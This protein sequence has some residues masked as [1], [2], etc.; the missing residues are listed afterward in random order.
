MVEVSDD[1]RELTRLTR[2]VAKGEQAFD[3]RRAVIMRLWEAGMTQRELAERMTRASI[4]VGGDPVT[5]NSIYKL[6]MRERRKA[7]DLEGKIVRFPV[8]AQ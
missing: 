7:L 6:I 5:E 3:E 2:T 4:A 8:A 1:L